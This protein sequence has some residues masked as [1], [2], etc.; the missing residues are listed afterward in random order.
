MAGQRSLEEYISKRNFSETPEPAGA[1][2]PASP[3]RRYVV[4]KHA[5]RRLHF[6]FRLE[7]EGVLLSW[8]VT[9]GPSLD[10][11]DKRLAVRTEDHPVAYG[12]FEGVIPSGY[13]AGTV[14]LWDEG[15]WIPDGDVD[16]AVKKGVLKFQIQGQ[17]LRGGWALVRMK[18]K[19]RSDRENWLLIKEKDAEASTDKDPVAIWSE[20]VASGLDL[21]GIAKGKSHAL[22]EFIPPQLAVAVDTPPEG[23][24]WVHEIKHDGYRI[25]ALIQGKTVRLMTRNGHDWTQRY[26]P[27]ARALSA[28][29]LP[30]AVLDGE[31]VAL[32]DAGRSDFSQLSNGAAERLTYFVFDLLEFDGASLREK[33]LHV[34]KKK[35]RAILPS[36]GVTVRFS[37]DLQG[38]GAQIARAACR[39]DL[40]GIVSKRRGALYRPGRHSSWQKSK[41]IGRDEFV[42]GGYRRSDKKGRPFASLL[43]G[44]YEGDQLIYRGRVGTGFTDTAMEQLAGRMEGLRRTKS[45][46]SNIPSEA[47]RDAVWLEPRLVAEVTYPEQTAA[48]LLRHSSFMGLREDKMAK[49][50][51]RQP[52]PRSKKAP[53]PGATAKDTLEIEG[54][55]VT[56]ATRIVFP[57]AGLTKGEVARW[58]DLAAPRIIPWLSNR[59]VSLFR[60]PDGI[61]GECFFQ[62]HAGHLPDK[63]RRVS[64]RE[65]SGSKADYLLINDKAGLLQAAQMGM[66][67]LHGWAAR[68][69]RLDRPDRMI[70][71]L[72]P[73]PSVSF[74]QVKGAA[75]D[76]RQ[77]LDQVGLASFPMVTG[78][79]GVHVMVPLMR[80]HGWDDVGSVSRGIARSLA[81]AAP[82]RFIATASLEK[83]KGRIFIDWLRN[84]RGATAI[85][86][87][88]LRARTSAA[89]AAPVTWKEL[90]TLPASDV[91]TPEL[92][93]SRL[94]EDPWKDI[95]GHRQALT[96]SMITVFSEF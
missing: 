66:I 35:L 24:D 76:I 83:R 31:L 32:N 42:I 29:G 1:E 43:L 55:S 50:V 21:E 57:N 60:C 6:D 54:V 67:E 15:S 75:E 17:R 34:R 87:Y 53:L 63:I 73:D 23:P 96:S 80:R 92:A 14:L 20:S 3:G 90:A 48:G 36:D 86:P 51:G 5:A 69:D 91:F 81:Q 2:Q 79:K 65:K 78:G 37:E 95:A 30:S 18:P 9:R 44:E 27:V 49:E 12:T 25:Q 13:G 47:R 26:P 11:A 77:L 7:H 28:L 62:K 88:S 41:C 40:E 85:V 58:Y 93:P 52:A 61:S 74:D 64:I 72:D 10:P 94:K 38:D 19:R 89:I 33:P 4:Q 71:D 70:F 59:P 68:A 46:F 45:P 16:E 22:P 82:E 84:R 8:A 39:M 56:H